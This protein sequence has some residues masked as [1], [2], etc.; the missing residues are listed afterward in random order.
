MVRR[1][2]FAVTVAAV[3]LWTAPHCQAISTI[4]AGSED[5]LG[6]K[7]GAE[8]PQISSDL[9]STSADLPSADG[10]TPSQAQAGQFLHLLQDP[11]LLSRT[12]VDAV[13]VERSSAVESAPLGATGSASDADWAWIYQE[14]RVSGLLT[15]CIPGPTVLEQ[16][17]FGV[18]DPED[19]A[20]SLFG[21]SP[22]ASGEGAD[23]DEDGAVDQP[24]DLGSMIRSTGMQFFPR[25]ERLPLKDLDKTV[26]FN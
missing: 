20:K 9:P 10:T 7:S 18:E 1:P 13:P 8:F 23:G 11:S 26:H 6:L 17:V 19:V 16:G 21:P 4:G 3:A 2:L 5:P 12:P 22:A 24:S 14:P 25:V 15:D